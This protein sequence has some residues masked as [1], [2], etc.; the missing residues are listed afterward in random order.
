MDTTAFLC[1]VVLGNSCGKL[2]ASFNHLA[3]SNKG[4]LK[5]PG[6]STI[7]CGAPTFSFSFQF[8]GNPLGVSLATL[9]H[10]LIPPLFVVFFVPGALTS[11]AQHL[12]YLTLKVMLHFPYRFR[13]PD[14]NS[15]VRSAFLGVRE[16]EL[17]NVLFGKLRIKLPFS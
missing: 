13:R 11:G 8:H 12:G 9:L 1:R 16:A 15:K 2:L 4:R 7:R 17:V 6:I 10:L 5:V 3:R 14:F